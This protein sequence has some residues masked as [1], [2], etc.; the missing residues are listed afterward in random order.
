MRFLT[1]ILAFC[2]LS[3]SIFAQNTTAPRAPLL[4]KWWLELADK[5]GTPHTIEHPETFLSAR[6]IARRARVG[7]PTT[8]EDLPVSPEYLAQLRQQGFVLHG[9]SRWLNGVAI[10]ADTTTAMQAAALPFV[11]SMVNVGR[12]IR[13]KNPPN[14][15]P[16]KR[17]AATP[18][19]SVEKKFGPLGYGSV[20][21]DPINTPL[22]HDLG[23]R[24]TGIWVAVMDGGFTNTDTIPLFD[25][26]A[27]AGRLWPGPDFVE[28]DRAVYESAH[29]GTS[30]LSVMAANAPGY[31][32]GAAPDATYFLLKTEDTGG[33]FP[34]EE[35]N[36]ILGAEWADSIGI[37]IVNASLGY[38]VFNN[39]A[40]NRPYSA[41]DGRSTIGAR[42]AT[43]AAQKG[44]IICNSAGNSGDETWH[45]IGVPAD[46][47]G[48]VA[49]GATDS[50][51]GK[52]APFSSYGPTADGRIKPDLSVPGLNVVGAGNTGYELT[53]TAGTSIASP[54][55][56]GSI[57]ALWGAFPDRSSK[58]ILE[59]VYTAA[60]QYSQPDVALG[61]G[62]PDMLSAW[63]QLAG[64]DQ[65]SASGRF[66]GYDAATATLRLLATGQRVGNEYFKVKNLFGQT[67]FE[68]HLNASG[69]LV[70]L[71]ECRLP[72]GL[73]SGWYRLEWAGG[74]VGFGI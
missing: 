33:E 38:T 66:W 21:L 17:V 73:P 25:S 34:I 10:I 39:A 20:N 8:F 47:P 30:V 2:L 63:F 50:Q 60:N 14:L 56:A 36:W 26:L 40:Y 16:K 3:S 31:F 41:L 19:E 59:A 45:Y 23:Q 13:I 1:I 64:I 49:V 69:G 48:V 29:H 62:A 43:I 5:N 12:D 42:G 67:V 68:S 18:P 6:S 44:M 24:G 32:V 22:L 7:A 61:Y 37:D 4:Y 70:R 65:Q 52:H 58:E 35:V 28:H 57:A 53:M 15:P 51:T 46:A 9:A 74:V 11:K 54:I 55:L 27:L 71:L 72:F